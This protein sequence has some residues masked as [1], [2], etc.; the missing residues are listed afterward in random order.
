MKTEESDL[1]PDRTPVFFGYVLGALTATIIFLIISCWI[2]YGIGF[3]N[4]VKNFSH[5]VFPWVREKVVDL[6]DG[7]LEELTALSAGIENANN[8]TNLTPHDTIFVSPDPELGHR[9]KPNV[10]VS[11]SILETTKAFNFDPPVLFYRHNADLSDD[12]NEFIKAKSR[13]HF[14]YSSDSEGFRKTLPIVNADKAV[15]IIGDSV[16]F[17]VGVDDEFTVASSLQ[18]K[19]GNRY[20]VINASV[21]GYNG[22]QAFKAAKQLSQKYDFA[23]LIY[24]ACQNDFHKAKDWASE[25]SDVLTKI[26]TISNRFDQNVIVILETYMEYAL[27]DIFL[28]DGWSRKKIKKTH[29]LRQ[30]M[31]ELCKNNGFAYYDWTDMVEDY[32]VQKKSFLSGF[33][34][35]ADHVHLS[36]L[37]NRLLAEKLHYIINSEW[38]S[39]Q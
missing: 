39:I 18:Q 6:P 20:R 22:H 17:G 16:S 2:V 28:D 24:V 1:K 21:G 5:T 12:L 8:P 37:G 33:A 23:G 32:R 26:K 7:I 9:I 30:A 25:A 36:P 3:S 38:Q 15:L 19:F 34:L 10:T 11:A 13:H 27:R 35:Y 29:Q 14:T 31:P 4:V